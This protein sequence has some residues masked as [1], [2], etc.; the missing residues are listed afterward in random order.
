M[1]SL[2]FHLSTS[3][4]ISP[5]IPVK[6]YL[7][8]PSS[9]SPRQPSFYFLSM[10]STI[11]DTLLEWNQTYTVFV[12]LQLAY[13]TQH[14]VPKAHTCCSMCQNSPPFKGW[15]HILH[16]PQHHLFQTIPS[17]L[18]GLDM[19]FKNH[20]CIYVRISSWLCYVLP[21]VYVFM[22]VSYCFD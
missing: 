2:S 7:P 5:S 15:L 22:P 16:F 12:F 19:L 17:P 21:L 8:I 18:I 4:L 11:P 20:V 9:P 13:L 1:N 3:V 10:N 14:D 6:Q